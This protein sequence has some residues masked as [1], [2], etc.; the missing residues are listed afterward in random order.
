MATATASGTTQPAP[1]TVLLYG[2]DTIECAYYLRA[3]SG[4]GID[5]DELAVQREALRQSKRKDPAVI[6]LGDME[7]LLQRYGSSSGFPFV[8]IHPDWTIECGQYNNPSFYVTYRSEALWREGAFALHERF[9]AWALSLGFYEYK[10]EGLSRVD[11]TFDVYL[12]QVDFDEDRFVSLA[13]TDTRHR[14]D[15]RIRGFRFGESDVLMRVYDKVAEIRESSFKVWFYDIWG[16][17][18]DVWRVEW[19][20]RKEML[21]RFGIRTLV[22]LRERQ[23]DLLRYLAQEHDTLRVP[24]GDSNRS[25]WPLHPLWTELQRY[26]ALIEG[27]GV[28]REIDPQAAIRQR[29]AR[30]AISLYGYLKQVAALESL[31]LGGEYLT[32][33]E[34]MRVLGLLVARVHDPLVWQMDVTKRMDHI[35]LGQW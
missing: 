10:A 29:L 8:L 16:V 17:Q 20:A 14:R 27:L 19:Q 32:Q 23:G 9:R 25:R 11:S 15:R 2:H 12:P 1:Y 3:A 33:P 4:Q 6:A 21:R 26:I 22:D 34:A 35:R 28:Y 24:N 13:D 31:R 30:L 7:F 5:F 18:E